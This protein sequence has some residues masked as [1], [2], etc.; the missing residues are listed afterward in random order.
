MA[1]AKRARKVETL[2][3]PSLCLRLRAPY[4][5][6]DIHKSGSERGVKLFYMAE[7]CDTLQSKEKRNREH[8]ACLNERAIL[9]L[10]DHDVTW[11]LWCFPAPE[12]GDFVAVMLI[13]NRGGLDWRSEWC[14]QYLVYEYRII[15][16][17]TGITKYGM[18]YLPCI[19]V[20]RLIWYS[21]KQ[22]KI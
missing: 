2:K 12:R 17:K 19:L 20:D 13:A 11:K 15:R 14:P 4:F 3:Q 21:S 18:I 5:Y 6:P 16:P 7:Y 10:L 9:R 1:K 8:K 22:A